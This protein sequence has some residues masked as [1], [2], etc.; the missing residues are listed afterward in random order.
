M[1]L[2]Y[3]EARN[4]RHI[5]RDGVVEPHRWKYLVALPVNREEAWRAL[6]DIRA[7]A[8]RADSAGEILQIFER[9]FRVSLSQLVSL[10]DNPAW[11]S[12][13]FGGN[14]W[15][16]VAELVGDL[17]SCLGAGRLSDA[18]VLLHTLRVARHNTGA[19]IDKLCQLDQRL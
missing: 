5:V 13:P 1:S 3:H 9:R 7:K 6:Q 18:D 15:K 12:Q 19:V 11:R 8:R 16:G 4:V 10:Y 14:A 17:A 2:V